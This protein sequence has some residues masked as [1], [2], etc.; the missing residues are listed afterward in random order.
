[1]KKKLTV[2]VPVDFT[3]VSFK[4]IEFLAFLMDK[5]PIATH[6]V[7]VIEVNEADWA[8]GPRFAEAQ[9]N[10]ALQQREEKASQGFAALRQQVDFTFTSAILHGGLT[11]ALA[12]YANSKEIDLVIMGTTGAQGWH[13]TLSGSQ[14]QQLVRQV[15]VPVITIHQHAAVNPIHNLLWVA[16]FRD[17]NQPAPAVAAIKTLQQL[18]EA[19]LHLLQVLPQAGQ[20]QEPAILTAMQEFADKQH[21]QPYELHLHHENQV[22]AG[23]SNFN[24]GMEMDLVILG[25]HARKGLGHLLFGS[26]AETLVNRCTHPLLTYHLA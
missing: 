13:E 10:S 8:G 18:F 26:I 9:D 4:A 3:P 20:N 23:V 6:L 17:A 7:H 14:A 11:T 1:M 25:T 5:T 12:S 21:L 2:M 16:D 19:R 24:R 22:A 15:Q